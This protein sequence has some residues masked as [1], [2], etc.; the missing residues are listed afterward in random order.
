MKKNNLYFS[1]LVLFLGL[2]FAN[3]HNG[4]ESSGY[5][6]TGVLVNY[7]NTLLSGNCAQIQ[8]LTSSSSV[9]TYS[10]TGYNVP[11]GGCNSSTLGST[12]YTSTSSIITVTD[13]YFTSIASTLA[14][15][16]ACSYMA[17]VIA[18]STTSSTINTAVAASTFFGSVKTA[19]TASAL[20]TLIAANTAD[21]STGPKNCYTVQITSLNTI[22]VACAASSDAT[23]ASGNVAYYVVNNVSSDMATSVEGNR[24]IIKGARAILT[25]SSTSYDT[26]V[27]LYTP[28]AIAAVRPMTSTELTTF[29]TTATL[30]N[31]VS[32]AL[33]AG[34]YSSLASTFSALSISSNGPSCL[35]AITASS[36]TTKDYVIRIPAL[37]R[38]SNANLNSDILSSDKLAV[39]TPLI[40]TLSCVYGDTATATATSASLSASTPAVG[41]CPSTYTKF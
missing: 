9:V 6:T 1:A 34:L 39:T 41:L 13:A 14:N 5:L 19:T 32:Y 37:Q 15:Y 22:G 31:T 8:K 30:L 28:T 27:A 38:L 12:Y 36:A 7:I 40:P 16:P 25:S 29:K 35:S 18:G 26:T 3:C 23:T 4:S 2:S 33:V 24:T 10:A 21:S 11:S 20:A 17:S